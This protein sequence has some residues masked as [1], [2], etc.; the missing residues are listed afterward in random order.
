MMMTK[1]SKE[2]KKQK[3]KRDTRYM[4]TSPSPARTSNSYQKGKISI[5]YK[6]CDGVKARMQ[7][8]PYQLR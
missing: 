4:S 8:N 5:N 1:Y 3:E 6:N 7:Q 2:V